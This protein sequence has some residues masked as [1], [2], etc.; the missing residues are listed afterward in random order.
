MSGLILYRRPIGVGLF[1]I[2]FLVRLPPC[3][4]TFTVV[5]IELTIGNRP[6]IRLRSGL[7]AVSRSIGAIAAILRCIFFRRCF[8]R[9]SVLCRGKVPHRT[10]PVVGKFL[11]SLYRL[12]FS[13][14]SYRIV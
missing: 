8:E 6:G 13:E 10:V 2:L 11:F 9:V 4:Y 5:E 7:V 1:Y 3:L 12:A 14:I